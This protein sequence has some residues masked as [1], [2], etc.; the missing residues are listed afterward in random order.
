MT[1]ALYLADSYLEKC[2]AAV[3]ATGERSVVLDRTVFYP[4]GGGQPSDTGWLSAPDGRRWE[5][6]SV[7]KSD[8]GIV[9]GVGSS[10]LPPVG[11]A[12]E[13]K[14][15]WEARYQHMRY[16]TA[17]HLLSGVVFHRFGSGITGGQI[18]VDRARM[19]FSL[20]EFNREL[21]AD[22]LGEMNRRSAEGIPVSARTVTRSAL[23]ADPSLVRVARELLPD[24]DPVRL[25]EIGTF[26]VQADGGTHVRST[27]EVGTARVER[28]EN[29]GARNKRLYISLDPPAPA[30]EGGP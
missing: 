3:V 16:H 30:I 14:I 12:V 19:D 23:D 21:A 18:Y 1:D 26:D 2:S 24:V 15:R 25:I 11:T 6:V 13:A 9:H 17:L 8:G 10:D 20:P 4:A 5:V 27:R 29:K 7:A 22:L 28:I